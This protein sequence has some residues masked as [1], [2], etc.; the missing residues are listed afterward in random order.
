MFSFWVHSPTPP[1]TFRTFR[2]FLLALTRVHLSW[3]SSLRKRRLFQFLRLL[4]L[5]T[6]LP[7]KTAVCGARFLFFFSIFLVIL[8]TCVHSPAQLSFHP[9]WPF[10]DSLS[11]PLLGTSMCGCFLRGGWAMF[12]FFF[13]VLC[14]AGF[15]LSFPFGDFMESCPSLLL[16]HNPIGG[17]PKGLFSPPL[18]FFDE[19]RWSFLPSHFLRT[20]SLPSLP[21]YLPIRAFPPGAKPVFGRPSLFFGLLSLFLSFL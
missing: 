6:P 5:P 7:H 2:I 20:S 15:L 19:A 1:P 21:F 13:V 17:S 14:P 12:F 9:M 10:S 8:G 3:H 11:P 4:D 18:F 16:C